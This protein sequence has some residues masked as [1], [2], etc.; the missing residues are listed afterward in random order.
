MNSIW[1][2]V[3]VT[4]APNNAVQAGL[5]SP[6]S[7]QHNTQQ[8]CMNAGKILATTIT[9]NMMGKVTVHYNCHE[10]KFDKLWK[11]LPNA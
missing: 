3:L 2:L 1:F 10:I 6:P 7:A 11:A 5:I 4:I 9:D 8:G